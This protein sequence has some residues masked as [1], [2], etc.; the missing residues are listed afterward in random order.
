MDADLMELLV[1]SGGGQ[2]ESF[3]PA[4]SCSGR[5]TSEIQEDESPG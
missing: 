2:T 1:P 5:G 3:R 4:T